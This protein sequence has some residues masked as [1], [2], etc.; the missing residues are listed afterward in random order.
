MQTFSDIKFK[1]L[2]TAAKIASFNRALGPTQ[3]KKFSF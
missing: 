3:I 2:P 1:Q